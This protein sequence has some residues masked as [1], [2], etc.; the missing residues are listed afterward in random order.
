MT[1]NTEHTMVSD[2]MNPKSKFSN[3]TNVGEPKDGEPKAKGTRSTG[4]P[5]TNTGSEKSYEG[6]SPIMDGYGYLLEHLNPDDPESE[7]DKVVKF[8]LDKNIMVRNV[9]ILLARYSSHRGKEF[10]ESIRNFINLKIGR[11]TPG[12]FGEDAI[13][14]KWWAELV[15]SVPINDTKKIIKELS[16]IYTEGKGVSMKLKGGKRNVV[17][18]FLGQGLSEI[19]HAA[20]I[21]H[22]TFKLLNPTVSGRFSKEEDEIILKEVEKTGACFETWKQLCEMLN[23]ISL[24]SISR[25]YNCL[26]VEKNFHMGRWT[27]AEDSIFLETLFCGK[28][29]VNVDEIQSL[30]F[31]SPLFDSLVEILNR[32]KPNIMERWRICIKPILLAH[33]YGTLHFPWHLDYFK[34]LVKMKIVA[35]QQISFPEVVKIFPEQSTDSLLNALAL[36]RSKRNYKDK[37][38]YQIIQSCLPTYKDHQ[39]TERLKN[40]REEIVRIYEEVKSRT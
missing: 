13:L 40:F 11:F 39:N 4:M 37:P 30:Q 35:P 14:L 32:P 20:D 21:F 34:Y 22:H 9:S 7:V 1:N 27:L 23:R 26:T 19:R 2:L 8:I 24:K 16:N 5:K 31:S 28:R 17:G 25:R 6:F 15:S 29:N 10:Y 3:L 38:L 33:H 36:F 12:K 18:C